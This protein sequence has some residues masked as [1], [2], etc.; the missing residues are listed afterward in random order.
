MLAYDLLLKR[1]RQTLREFRERRLNLVS[2]I[3]P[4]DRNIDGTNVIPLTVF[5]DLV[6]TWKLVH[7]LDIMHQKELTL[8]EKLKPNESA[9]QSLIIQLRAYKQL[10]DEYQTYAHQTR[11]PLNPA[12]NDMLNTFAKL[13]G[14]KG[15]PPMSTESKT[16]AHHKDLKP[17]EPVDLE[18]FVKRAVGDSIKKGYI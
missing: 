11:E 5:D 12:S 16:Y 8:L 15:F 14:I 3:Q 17:P 7:G 4:I 18:D 13:L 1:S 10:H 6:R 9:M 2:N